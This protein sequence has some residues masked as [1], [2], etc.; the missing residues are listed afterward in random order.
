MVRDNAARRFKRKRQKGQK[1]PKVVN[2]REVWA[3]Q[4]GEAIHDIIEDK[5]NG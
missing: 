1:A 4:V 3:Q 5:L 2:V